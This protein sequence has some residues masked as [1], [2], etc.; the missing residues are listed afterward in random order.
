MEGKAEEIMEYALSLGA[1]DVVVNAYEERN[2]QIRFSNNRMDIFNGWIERHYVLFLAKQKRVV[3]TTIESGDVYKEIVES[4][5]RTA[6]L[7]PPSSDYVGIAK[8]SNARSVSRRIET[9]RDRTLSSLVSRAVDIAQR[10]GAVSCAGSLYRN[11]FNRYLCTSSGIRKKENGASLH[12]SIRCFADEN[13]SGHAVISSLR[14][15]DF[16]PEKAAEKA[17]SLSRKAINAER[18]MEGRFDAILDPMVSAVLASQIAQMDSAYSIL[19]G[20][21]CLR[22]K[23]GKRVASSLLTVSDD[24]TRPLLGYRAFDDEGLRVRRTTFISKGVLKTYLH[25]TSTARKFR[26]RSTGNA[27]LIYPTPFSISVEAGKR[28]FEDMISDLRDG[29]YINNVWY[30][31]Y[32]NYALGNFSTIPRDAILRIRNGE[33]AGAL[34][35]M[36]VTENLLRVLKN[37]ADISEEREHVNWWLESTVPS[38]VPYMLVKR[39]NITRSSDVA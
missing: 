29:I 33:I 34:R 20:F 22:G 24:A 16:E 37:V 32:Q 39:L 36:R 10:N 35:D 1:D 19:S 12:F 25:N 23:I 30:T 15:K 21:S 17:A 8:R 11:S 2:R 31:R 38:T 14:L 9:A 6:E 4:A 28:H 18:A 13:A 27:G 5:I 7:S 26:T 3:A